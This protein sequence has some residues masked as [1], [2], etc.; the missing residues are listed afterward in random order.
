MQSI[1]IACI[2]VICKCNLGGAVPLTPPPHS[3]PPLPNQFSSFFFLKV[4]L[5]YNGTSSRTEPIYGIRISKEN[6]TF[7]CRL[8]WPFA[9]VVVLGFLMSLWN[10]LFA[11]GIGFCCHWNWLFAVIGISFSLSLELAFCCTFGMGFLL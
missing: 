7:C 5:A 8:N 4:H 3:P 1:Y 9:A 2:G 6:H 10:R 11:V